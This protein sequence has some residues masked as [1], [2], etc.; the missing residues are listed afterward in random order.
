MTYQHSCIQCNTSFTSS[1]PQSKFCSGKCRVAYIRTK[2]EKIDSQVVKITGKP[3][4][5]AQEEVGEVNQLKGGKMGKV[6]MA[7]INNR[8]KVLSH[9]L[10]GYATF[11]LG[12]E[13]ILL[14]LHE[15]IIGNT[16]FNLGKSKERRSSDNS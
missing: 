10:S 7:L 8:H 11:I 5:E 14:G 13:V 16:K 15:I 12:N 9:G 4:E 6:I 1:R 2:K 3:Q